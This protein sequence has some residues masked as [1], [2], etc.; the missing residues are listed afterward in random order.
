MRP[1]NRSQQLGLYFA[2]TAIAMYA[3]ARLLWS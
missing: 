1:P 3:V 2:L